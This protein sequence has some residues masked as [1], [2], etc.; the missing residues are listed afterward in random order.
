MPP[1]P[2][3]PAQP[4][5]GSLPPVA[6]DPINQVHIG[7]FRQ[8]SQ[9]VIQELIAALPP[10]T[11][12]LM[13]NIPLV[14]DDEVGS[15]NAFAAC[16]DGRALMAIT[17]GLLEILGQM[18][19]SRATDEVFR[20]Q[21]FDQYLQLIARNQ[22][23]KQ[24]I[25]RPAPGFFQP[26]QDMD[27]VKVKRQHEIFDEMLA[28][29][30][31]HELAHHYLKHTGCVGQSGLPSDLGRLLSN[32]VPGF[33]QPNELA[34]D[35]SGTDNLLTAGARRQGYKWTSPGEEVLFAF[36]ISHPPPWVRRPSVQQAAAAWRQRGG[37]PAAPSPFPFPF[38]FPP[39]GG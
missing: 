25:I 3:P 14:V 27:G 5:P 8:R 21:K 4:P 36:E 29:V 1:G 39:A 37:R 22:K 7:F 9:G 38:P 24:P 11:A 17:D 34:S 18:A 20:T 32:V 16:I 28:F 10:A 26:Q 6:N 35:Q 30:L 15:V 33:N 23:P 12:Q 2:Q 13:R 31:G 19:R